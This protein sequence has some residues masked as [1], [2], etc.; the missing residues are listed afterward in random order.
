MCVWYVADAEMETTTAEKTA[1]P[2]AFSLQTLF[3]DAKA[4][5]EGFNGFIGFADGSSTKA[6][7]RLVPPEAYSDGKIDWD[8]PSIMYIDLDSDLEQPVG[9]SVVLRAAGPAHSGHGR[10]SSG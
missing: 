4:A 5:P 3:K 8:H 2:Q 7:I 10:V 1:T 6:C 9:V